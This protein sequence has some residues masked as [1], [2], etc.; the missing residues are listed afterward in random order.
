MSKIESEVLPWETIRERIYGSLDNPVGYRL[1]SDLYANLPKYFDEDTLNR[2]IADYPYSDVNPYRDNKVMNRLLELKELAHKYAVRDPWY[3]VLSVK[4]V[5]PYSCQAKCAFCYNKHGEY[6]NQVCHM[7]WKGLDYDTICGSIFKVMRIAAGRPISIEITGGEPTAELVEL[8]QFTTALMKYG[9]PTHDQIKRITLTSNGYQLG[10][11][12]YSL[13]GATKYVNLSLHSTDFEE[14][15]KI[16]GTRCIPN[17]EEIVKLTNDAAGYGIDMSGVFVVDDFSMELDKFDE[18]NKWCE[19][20]GLVSTRWRSNVFEKNKVGLKAFAEKLADHP[21]YNLV[22]YEEAKDSS[23]AIFARNGS[24]LVY[25]LD[26]V[27]DATQTSLGVSV[28]IRA[29]GKIFHDAACT[30]PVLNYGEE[31]FLPLK[32]VYDRKDVNEE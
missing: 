3:S 2:M 11:A 15:T 21:S 24:H 13:H 29:D 32:Y 18:T 19:I 17:D 1:L 28:L 8:E 30:M 4:V 25:L 14:R 6:G 16:F 26:G 27:E 10:H 5:L 20:H 31:G 9:I 22:V 7:S 23:Y 12:L